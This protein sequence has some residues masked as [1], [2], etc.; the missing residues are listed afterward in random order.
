MNLN[1]N[2]LKNDLTNPEDVTSSFAPDDMNANKLYAMLAAIPILF[3]LPLV[4]CPASAYGKHCANQG[5]I[6]LI[7]GVV[8][9]VVSAIIGIIPILGAIIG[10]ILGLVPFAGFLLLFVSAL[11]GKARKLP[12]I[13]N[14][15]TAF[16]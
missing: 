12:I 9:S 7:L 13:G 3:W 5:L 14:L 10:W 1:K 8:V 2:D 16:N 15:F 6:L 11:Q 4:A